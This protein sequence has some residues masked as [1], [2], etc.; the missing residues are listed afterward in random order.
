MTRGFSR[1]V[2]LLIAASLVVAACGGD[3]DDAGDGAD[4]ATAT[5]ETESASAPTT[6]AEDTGTATTAPAASATS[7]DAPATTAASEPSSAASPET[8]APAAQ[9]FG[10]P[11]VDKIVFSGVSP[12]AG[13]WAIQAG[14]AEGIFEDYGVPTEMIFSASSPAALAALM[15]GSVQF[16][17]TVYD[18]GIQ[19]FLQNDDV[20]YVAGGYDTFPQELIFTPDITTVEDLRGKVCGAANPPG[21]GDHLY[22]QLMITGLSGGTMKLG[23]DY[24]I[25]NVGAQVPAI[26]AAFEAGQI[27]CYVTLPPS[28]GLLA[29]LGYTSLA[30]TEDSPEFE[31]YPFFGINTLRS[32]VEDN[33]N[34]AHAFLR[35]YLASIAWL[36]DPANKDRAIEILATNAGLEP[37]VAA[38]A[39]AW[40]ERGGYPRT[41][42]MDEDWIRRTVEVQKQFG[43]LVALERDIAPEILDNSFVEMAYESL[44]DEVKN[45]PGP[46]QG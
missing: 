39:Y 14:V 17:S 40:V 37:E 2:G 18:A 1:T 31:G 5:D 34:S 28:T 26:A 33:P 9:E 11:E 44:P 23:D 27:S 42:A 43:A 7:D 46:G 10:E 24:T 8:T 4:S 20:I 15:S 19:A 25:V 41:G 32:W 38:N 12:N 13:N 35:G 36:Y 29:G 30:N 22:T 45:G 3:D 6:A 16:T 21:T